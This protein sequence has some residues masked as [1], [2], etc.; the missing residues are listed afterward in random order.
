MYMRGF[1][2]NYALDNFTQHN[3]ESELELVH[4]GFLSLVAGEC[5]RRAN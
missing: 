3:T 1:V 5:K 2:K 4:T